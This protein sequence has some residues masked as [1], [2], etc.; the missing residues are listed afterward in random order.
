MN[1]VFDAFPSKAQNI[2][3]FTDSLS[4]LQALESGNHCSAELAQINLDTNQLMTSHEVRI[5]MQWIPGHSNIPGNDKADKLAKKGAR[6]EQPFTPTSMRTV[7]QLLKSAKTEEW[8][9][10]W[11]MGK[12]GREIYKHMA[13]PNP[14]DNINLLE[15]RDQ[16]TIFRLRTKHIQ[17]N[18]H[19]N[20]IQPQHSPECQLCSHPYETVE[21]HLFECPA[22]D[23][24]RKLLLPPRPDKWNTLYGTKQ[25]LTNTCKYHYM[26]LSQR[27]EA[28]RLLDQ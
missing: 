21:H 11:A 23:S 3:I 12:T 27:A 20:R 4:A 7:K 13:T 26:A 9:N 15:R 16:S 28:H 25:Q 5:V 19:L 8:L 10:R 22:L 1:T 18:N 14:K 24:A 6:Q 17:L 2:V